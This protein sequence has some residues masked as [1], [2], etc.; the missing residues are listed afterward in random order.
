MGES[1]HDRRKRELAEYERD[2]QQRHRERAQGEA[3]RAR[4]SLEQLQSDAQNERDHYAEELAELQATR[5]EYLNKVAELEHIV[6][7]LKI[8]NV[9]VGGRHEKLREGIQRT[10]RRFNQGAIHGLHDSLSML[11]ARDLEVDPPMELGIEMPGMI[12]VTGR[13]LKEG[14]VSF[15][16]TSEGLVIR[17]DDTGN[18]E[19]WLQIVCPETRLLALLAQVHRLRHSHAS[20][21]KADDT[22]KP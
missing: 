19:F 9:L 16:A 2:E 17:V 10:L 5:D 12:P 13:G 15:Q 18:D 3:E 4:R 20:P 22:V 8:E 6:S 14:Q 1:A 7:E 21:P 11:L